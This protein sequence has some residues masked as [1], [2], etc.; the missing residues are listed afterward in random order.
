MVYFGTNASEWKHGRWPWLVVPEIV[1]LAT[2]CVMFLVGPFLVSPAG[3]RWAGCGTAGARL[4]VAA[5]RL[6]DL[7]QQRGR[8]HRGGPFVPGRWRGLPAGS[9]SRS[10]G[11]LVLLLWNQID[12]GHSAEAHACLLA[13]VGGDESGRGGERSGG[14]VPGARTGEHSDLRASL[15]R[16]P[17]SRRRRRRRSSISC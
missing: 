9:R 16:P 1:L 3:Q 8:A 12:D 6:A 11:L 4:G 17:R 5:A 7:V 13:I 10:G 14:A 15:S 2:V